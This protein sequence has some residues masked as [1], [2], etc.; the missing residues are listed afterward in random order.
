MDEKN[1]KPITY[2]IYVRKSSESEDRQV[3]S[4]V[5]QK[6]ELKEVIDRDGLVVHFRVFEESQ[7]AFKVGRT[8]FSE[9]VD[10]T[11]RGEVNAWIC[12][13]ANRLS[14]N[15]VDGGLIVHLMDEGVLD[16]IRT[17]E[18]TYSNTPQDKLML[19]FEFGLSK[20]DSEEKSSIVRSGIRRRNARGY[21]NGFPPVG[22]RLTGGTTSSGSSFWDVDKDQLKIVRMIFRR[23]LQGNDS[24]LTISK[25][26]KN[27]GL[28][29]QARRQLGG[30]MPSRSAIHRL[31]LNPVYS[32][33]FFSRDGTRYELAKELP[34]IITEDERSTIQAILG[35][36]NSVKN[37]IKRRAAFKGI[38]QTPEGN[39]L[40]V[41]HK[42]HLVCDCHHKFSYIHREKCPKCEVLISALREPQFRSYIYYYSLSLRKAFGKSISSIEEKSLREKTR[43]YIRENLVLPKGSMTWA[44]HYLHE[45]QDEALRNRRQEARKQEKFRKEIEGKRRKLRELYLDALISKK[46]Y[47]EEARM[48]SLANSVKHEADFTLSVDWKKEA[49]H[50]LEI[51]EEIDLVLENGN[52]E[53]VNQTME[54]LGLKLIWNGRELKFRQSTKLRRLTSL[55]AQGKATGF[56]T[57]PTTDGTPSKQSSNRL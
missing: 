22:F 18:R 16:H 46:E 49:K 14:R 47:E 53:E 30:R 28:R 13:H 3:Q 8:V 52:A 11:R 33:F 55:I 37:Q 2:G 7:S 56:S 34:R 45:L 41:D 5:R 35:D 31:L 48:L 27:I 25:F 57:Y 38:I 36:H 15:P 40:G 6:S 20:N 44:L 43:N 9:L 24:V 50:M 1:V 32:G 39:D 10:A 29:T 23:F 12:W 26:A 54:A 51:V 4:L 21:P 17:R 19:H 42:F